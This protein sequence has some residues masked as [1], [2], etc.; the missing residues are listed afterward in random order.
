MSLAR[1]RWEHQ[2]E[3]IKR[4]A[5]Q[6]RDLKQNGFVRCPLCDRILEASKT[7]QCDQC[8]TPI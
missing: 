7:D 2:L 1:R 5:R 3:K 6:D 8:G 4:Q